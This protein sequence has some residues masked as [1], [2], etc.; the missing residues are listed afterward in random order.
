MKVEIDIDLNH[1]ADA[2]PYDCDS[3]NYSEADLK[4]IWD[5]LPGNIKSIAYAWGTSDTEFRDAAFVWLRDHRGKWPE[6]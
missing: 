6:K 2:L 1:L 4:A 3:K 5:K